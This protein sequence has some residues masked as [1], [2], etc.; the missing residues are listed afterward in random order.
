[1]KYSGTVDERGG[2]TMITGDV[3]DSG[4]TLTFDLPKLKAKELIKQRSIT[5]SFVLLPI[6][7]VYKTGGSLMWGCEL[8][9]F[10]SGV[11]VVYY[12]NLAADNMNK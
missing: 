7:N 9:G 1:M 10:Q 5:C 4:R 8:L 2:K 3:A 11:T 12:C 6:Y